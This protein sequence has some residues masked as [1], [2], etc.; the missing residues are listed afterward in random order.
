MGDPLREAVASI[1]R[2]L[3]PTGEPPRWRRIEA[4]ATRRGFPSTRSFRGWCLARGVVLREDSQRDTWV[5]PA[6]IDAAVERMPTVVRQR[7]NR[8]EFDN[9]IDRRR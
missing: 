3:A 1:V 2:D 6:A 7:P 5:E 4:E 8:S 9:D